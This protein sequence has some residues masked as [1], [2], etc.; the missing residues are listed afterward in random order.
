MTQTSGKTGLGGEKEGGLQRAC[1]EGG[2][3]STPFS[4]VE[5][6]SLRGT[7]WSPYQASL[8]RQA[9]WSWRCLQDDGGGVPAGFSQACDPVPKPGSPPR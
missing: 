5:A 1:G 7:Q 9:S 2:D 4:G 8:G 6:Q 3:V